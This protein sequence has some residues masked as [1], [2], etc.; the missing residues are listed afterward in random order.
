MFRKKRLNLLGFPLSEAGFMVGF[1][2]AISSLF[3]LLYTILDATGRQGTDRKIAISAIG[4]HIGAC[5]LYALGCYGSELI[6]ADLV[7]SMAVFK[8]FDTCFGIMLDLLTSGGYIADAAYIGISYTVIHQSSHY[9][10]VWRVSM[11]VLHIM[12]TIALWRQATLMSILDVEKVRIV[13]VDAQTE[14]VIKSERVREERAIVKSA[15]AGDLAN[16][17]MPPKIEH[18]EML[19]GRVLRGSSRTRLTLS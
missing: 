12:G 13:A 17:A 6:H 19:A 15:K 14:V 8:T 4:Y 5:I 18:E 3:L 11:T 7:Y 2:S 10:I 16:E 9:W 1:L